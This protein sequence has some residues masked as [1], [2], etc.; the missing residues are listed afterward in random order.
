MVMHFISFSLVAFFGVSISIAIYYS[1]R[2]FKKI[3][4]LIPKKIM[5]YTIGTWSVFTIIITF[6]YIFLKWRIE[7]IDAEYESYPTFRFGFYLLSG[8]PEVLIGALVFVLLFELYLY[9]NT[10][11]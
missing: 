4:I 1:F 8:I 11:E 6:W 2:S 10:S 9:R 7:G 5:R 3:K